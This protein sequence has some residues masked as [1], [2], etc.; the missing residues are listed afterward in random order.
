MSA[1]RYP[2]LQEPVF[3]AAMRVSVESIPPTPSSRTKWWRKP[4]WRSAWM[5]NLAGAS[6]LSATSSTEVISSPVG[7]VLSRLVGRE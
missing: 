6:A 2:L 7:L 5:N 1:F 3:H 4:H